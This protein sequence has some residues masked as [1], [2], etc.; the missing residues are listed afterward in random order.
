MMKETTR[1]KKSF[2]DLYNGNPWLD[3][4]LTGT[5]KSISA[6]QAIKRAAP[7]VNS[8]WEITNHLISWRGAVLQRVHGTVIPSPDDNYFLPVEDISSKAWKETLERLEESEHEWES[9]LQDMKESDLEKLYPVN[10]HTYYEHIIGIIQHDAYH[11]GQIV[12]LAKHFS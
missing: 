11:L 3:V 12:M 8:I 7:G 10:D 6:K 9:F 4:T 2:S 1:L 5:L